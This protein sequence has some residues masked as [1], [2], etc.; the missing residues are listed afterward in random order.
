M[1]GDDPGPTP[2]VI[3]RQGH[4]RLA[5]NRLALNRLA[6][7]RLALNSLALDH[8]DPAQLGTAFSEVEALS[9]DQPGGRSTTM[10]YVA[11]CFLPELRQIDIDQPTTEYGGTG[12]GDQG[13]APRLVNSYEGAIGIGVANLD[14]DGTCG[15]ACQEWMTS[16]L[17]AHVNGLGIEVSIS[18]RGPALQLAPSA[19]E[20][21]DYIEQE[22][23]FFGNLFV[24]QDY[25]VDSTGKLP[26][27]KNIYACAG[28]HWDDP[29]QTTNT[30]R[31][32]GRPTAIGSGCDGIRVVGYC[33][34]RLPG[35]GSGQGRVCATQLTDAGGT[36]SGTVI[37]SDCYREPLG[38]PLGPNQVP[39][40]AGLPYSRV[41][42]THLPVRCDLARGTVGNPRCDINGKT[43]TCVADE[44]DLTGSIASCKGFQ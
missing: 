38:G 13:D 6:L 43:G 33:G 42:T 5:L 18:L 3:G 1:V 20:A 2:T 35:S 34:A 10:E 41:I 27:L 25:A 4:N 26:P 37:Y 29:A 23:G 39:P 36:L 15:T 7:N 24:D 17:L 31:I 21:A 32:C 40:N 14:P 8:L 22:A 16:C 19:E 11:R 28:W 9:R 44:D 30:E 12:Y